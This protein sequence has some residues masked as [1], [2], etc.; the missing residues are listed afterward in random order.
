MDTETTQAPETELQAENWGDPAVDMMA[1]MDKFFEQEGQP[2]EPVPAEPAAP[3]EAVETPPADTV[4]ETPVDATQT[5][6]DDEP[7]LPEDFFPDATE[8]AEE[9]EETPA[10]GFD[11]EAFDKQTEEE[12]KGMEAKAG[13]KFRALKAELK[14]ARKA[15]VTPEVQTKLQELE[16][17]AAE[18]DGLKERMKELSSQ[19]AKLQMESEPRYEN[20]VLKPAALIFEKGNEIADAYGIDPKVINQLV[21]IQDRKARNEFIAEHLTGDHVPEEQRLNRVDETAVYQLAHEYGMLVGKRNEMLSKA[22]TLIEQGKI[23]RI[24]AQKKLLGDQRVAVQKLQKAEWEKF[25]DVIPG[26]TE[27]GKETAAYKKLMAVGMSIDFSTARAQDQAKAA[28][29]GV[30]LP[31]VVKQVIDLQKRLAAYEKDDRKK[32]ATGPSA[33]SSV[34]ASPAEKK[35]EDFMDAMAKDY[36]FTH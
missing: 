19:S 25:K 27:D 30:V 3:Q 20:E 4:P 10:D 32:V 1:E 24:E 5:P 31:H 12:V 17:K 26:L 8:A 9:T 2:S 22:E 6:S 16:L 28:F 13:E 7:V 18:V 23:E 15:T 11:E 34:A 29:S 36:N 14:E 35:A 21:R 33:S